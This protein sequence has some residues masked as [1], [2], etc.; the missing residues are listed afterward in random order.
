MDPTMDDEG[1]DFTMLPERAQRAI[2]SAFDAAAT[3]TTISRRTS[4]EPS[5]LKRR[6]LDLDVVQPGSF[7]ES[8]V[9]ASG[10]FLIDEGPSPGG[11]I[12]D[13][14]VPVGRYITDAGVESPIQLPL[15]LVPGAL[16]L[17]DLPPDDPDV[18]TI[19]KNA[20]AGWGSANGAAVGAGVSRKDWRAVCAV[21][22]AGR[23]EE[24]YPIVPIP[25]DEDEH[26]EDGDDGDDYIEQD[27][28]S[29]RSDSEASA[30]DA[31]DEEYGALQPRGNARRQ[32]GIGRQTE[33]PSGPPQLTARQKLASRAA[34][35]L[36][37]PDVPDDQLEFQ[38][39]RIRDLSRVSALLK[40]KLTAEEI[41]EMLHE[42]STAPDKSVGLSDFEQVMMLAQLV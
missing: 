28:D 5:P 12:A 23:P 24:E 42:F 4:M 18:L 6:R 37:F 29:A 21:L 3:T 11:F 22:L 9:P 1:G 20:A 38:R 31:S 25:R 19:F 40:E 16:Q 14:S 7:V 13:G 30:L 27:D 15:E 8:D 36:F 10:G 17:L 26:L 34:F 33:F 39:I 2:D 41:V 35:A 32:R